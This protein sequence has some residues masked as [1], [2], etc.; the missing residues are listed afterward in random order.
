MFKIKSFLFIIVLLLICGSTAFA[1]NVVVIVNSAS[2]I[3]NV[4]ASDIAKV[5][6]GKSSSLDGEKVKAVDLNEES[7]VRSSFSEKIL[8]RSVAKIVKLWKKKIFSGKGTPP[9][10]MSNDNEVLAYVAD[11]PNGIGYIDASKVTD[12]VKVISV[13]GQ[14][15][16]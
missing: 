1:G 6:M 5:F 2:S 12:K 9:Q 8:G 7:E 11:N 14:K 13:D 3:T 15:E 16:W 4:T 10:T